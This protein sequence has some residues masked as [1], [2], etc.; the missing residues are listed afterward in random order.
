[1]YLK[2]IYNTEKLPK[3]SNPKVEIESEWLAIIAMTFRDL[4][5]HIIHQIQTSFQQ[6]TP[7]NISNTD[8]E[9]Y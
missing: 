6:I 8:T 4:T 5:G 7:L 2:N 3:T 9:Q 1:M